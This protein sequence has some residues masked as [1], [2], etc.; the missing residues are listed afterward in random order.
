MDELGACE[1]QLGANECLY[2][3]RKPLDEVAE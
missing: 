2:V 1:R 3:L